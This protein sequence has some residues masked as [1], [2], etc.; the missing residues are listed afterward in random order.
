MN[1]KQVKR[2]A[3]ILSVCLFALWWVLGTSATIAWFTD[4]SDEVSNHFYFGTLTPQVSFRLPSGDY[5]DLSGSTQ[6]FDS[7]ARFEPGYTQVV[8]LKI[9]NK[10]SVDFS[11]KLSVT[12]QS[13]KAINVLGTEFC[14]HDYLK[15][16][17]LFADS[18][19]E[20]DRLTAQNLAQDGFA[21][22]TWSSVSQTPVAAGKTQY[23]ALVLYMPTEVD[24]HANYRGVPPTVDLGISVF[25]QQADAPLE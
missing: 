16:G 1:G 10:G 20:L 5:A 21:L 22:G 14:L 25:A 19:T 17:A 7:Q 13:T 3:W 6:V 8:Y 18:E 15:F 9:E 12:G 23:V 24:N 11:Y 2:T 4:T